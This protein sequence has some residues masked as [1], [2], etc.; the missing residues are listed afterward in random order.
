LLYDRARHE[1][2]QPIE[3]NESRARTAI[4]RIVADAEARF[5][6]EHYW[7]PHP[8]DSDTDTP[9]TPLYFGGIGMIWALHYL[10]D[11]GAA[12][13]AKDCLSSLQPLATDNQRWLGD[14]YGDSRGAYLMGDT[15]HLMMTYLRE[16][17]D[18]EARE[19]LAQLIAANIDHPSRELMWGAPGT[20]LAALFLYER[21][22]D[23]RWAE[24]FRAN[25]RHLWSQL[26]WSEDH[27][28]HYW[29]QDMYGT[30]STYLDAVHGFVATASPL[31][32]GRAL[33]TPSQW[34]AWRGCIVN[35]IG[36]TA[37]WENGEINWRAYLVVPQ[38]GTPRFLMQFCHGAPGFVV[39]L[40]DL[41]GDELDALL[42]AAG[43][44]IWSAGPLTKGSNLCHGTGGNGYAFLKLYRRTGDTRWLDRARAFAM[45]GI[46][47]TE[48]AREQYG[49]GRYSL[50]TGDVGFAIYLWDCLQG[51]AAFPT[52]DVF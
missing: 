9:L 18:A 21:T 14:E 29:T 4:E 47:Q 31:I 32:R 19:R 39:C 33:L 2:L 16:P 49:Q 35:T 41:P 38:G 25:A 5:S 37:T 48:R 26:Q 42:L 15:P 23:E 1:P 30:T 8:Q 27:G 51:T 52:L 6:P 13:L 36:R 34:Q 46:V 17:Q 43:E 40:G 50:W 11:V 28:C 10:R 20:M 45:H 22:R 44:T 3:W 12:S 7:P 24:A